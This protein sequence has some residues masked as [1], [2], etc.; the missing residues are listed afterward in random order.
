VYLGKWV[1]SLTRWRENV[2]DPYHRQLLHLFISDHTLLILRESLLWSAVKVQAKC[3]SLNI[4]EAHVAKISTVAVGLSFP[5]D[6]RIWP[7]EN[8]IS[9]RHKLSPSSTGSPR[10]TKFPRAVCVAVSARSYS[11]GKKTAPTLLG[12]LPLRR[13]TACRIWGLGVGDREGSK[14]WG[15]PAAFD[16]LQETMASAHILS[17]NRT[18]LASQ[19]VSSQLIDFVLSQPAIYL[20]ISE[21][22]SPLAEHPSTQSLS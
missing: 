18:G 8:P 14:I 6:H 15:G 10:G 11:P 12:L 9:E 13:L 4:I 16:E 17:I 2:S 22:R 21:V 5:Q 3:P 1:R 20:E 7:G 19:K